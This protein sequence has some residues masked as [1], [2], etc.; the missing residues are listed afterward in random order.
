MFL[1]G[2]LLP[3]GLSAQTITTFAGDG[4]NGILGDGSPA[5]AAEVSSA[6]LGAFDKYGNYY[7]TEEYSQV[8]RKIDTMGIISLFAGT[9]SLG[10]SGDSGEATT[11]TFRYPSGIACDTIGNVY[12]ADHQNYRI[13]KV[14]IATGI[15]Y[16]VIGSGYGFDSG[17]GGSAATAGLFPSDIHFDKRG[18]LYIS[19]PTYNKI[20]KVNIAGIISTYAGNGTLG[21]SGDNGAA[22]AA[23]LAQCSML[24]TDNEDNVYV[25]DVMNLRI[26][27][28]DTFGIITTIAGN[29]VGLYVS[30]GMPATSSPM[31]P[32]AI[33]IDANNQ[34]Y[35]ADTNNRVRLIDT[36]GIVHAFAG[37][38]TFGYNGSGIPAT[39]AW[40]SRPGG[41]TIDACGN[42]YFGDGGNYIIRK[43]TLP[44]PVLTIPI[45]SLS[46][47]AIASAGMTVTV[48]ATVANAG[49]SYTIEWMNHG[50]EFTTT[51]VPFVTYTKPPGIDTITAKIVPTGY[52]CLDSTTSAGLVVS[53]PS[54]VSNLQVK[55][56]LLIYPNPVSNIL[57]IAMYGALVTQA[58][59]SNVFGQVVEASPRPSFGKL[60]MTGEREVSLDVSHLPSG[61]YFVRVNG[62][63]VQ[64][65]IKE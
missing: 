6:D 24:A 38:G 22:T 18:N 9:G 55:E 32:Y 36:S 44:T 13:R 11:A 53:T 49:S 30:D 52:G 28:I 40:L 29:G 62:I 19:E 14:D 39:A 61:I 54:G 15:I 47:P 17:D 64:K 57:Y 56:G 20:R 34:I 33:G 23:K 12:I 5:T 37:N 48:T 65:F 16:T 25:T 50:I 46:S 8:V 43:V 41:I 3:M 42:V 63:Y 4:I 35:F 7:Y 51:T 26:R 58:T 31:D 60:T 1:V 21:F 59:I 45:I 2:Y 27:K 10:F